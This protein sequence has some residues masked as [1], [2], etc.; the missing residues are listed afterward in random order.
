MDSHKEEEANP[1]DREGKH[2]SSRRI[3]EWEE[4]C[5]KKMMVPSRKQEN[6]SE[7]KLSVFLALKASL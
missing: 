2:F 5:L 4:I 6:E 3:R 1:L 7:K